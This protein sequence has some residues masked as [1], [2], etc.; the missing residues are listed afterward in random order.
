MAGHSSDRS[1]LVCLSIDQH[2]SLSPSFCLVLF[3]FLFV[4]FGLVLEFVGSRCVVFYCLMLPR[5]VSSFIVLVVSCLSLL[6][7]CYTLLTL[8]ITLTLILT[9]SLTL[10]QTLFFF[11]CFRLKYNTGGSSNLPVEATARCL[12]L[13]CPVLSCPVLSCLVIILSCDYPVL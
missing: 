9:L 4:L 10:A 5:G 3:R 8:T 12:V 2:V 1:R 11:F 7:C 6:L 13:S